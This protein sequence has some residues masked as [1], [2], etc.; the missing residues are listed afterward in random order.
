[1]YVRPLRRVLHKRRRLKN[2]SWILTSALR[3]SQS[4]PDGVYIAGFVAALRREV[5]VVFGLPLS[6]TKHVHYVLQPF[7]LC[8]LPLRV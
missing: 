6:E 5:H 8:S 4:V 3:V 2:V 7:Q 1:M